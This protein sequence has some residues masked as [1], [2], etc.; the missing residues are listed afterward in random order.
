MLTIEPRMVIVFLTRKPNFILTQVSLA[1][2]IGPTPTH[3]LLKHKWPNKKNNQTMVVYCFLDTLHF[4]ALCLQ[5]IAHEVGFPHQDF[6]VREGWCFSYATQRWF[7]PQRTT[8]LN[9]FKLDL[10]QHDN[11]LLLFFSMLYKQMSFI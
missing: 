6:R 3:T 9:E 4:H 10:Q 8:P 1:Y 5:F 11:G 2:V 7:W